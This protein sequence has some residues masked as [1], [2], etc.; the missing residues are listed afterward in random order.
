[1][2]RIKQNPLHEPNFNPGAIPARGEKVRLATIGSTRVGGLYC[3]GSHH[4][5]PALDKA[6]DAIAQDMEGFYMGR[7]DVRFESLGKLR[8]GSGFTI[9]EVNGSGS[10][11]VHA[12]DPKYSIAESY[13]IIFAKQRLLFHIA[14][15]N[16]RKGHKPIGLFKLARLHFHQQKLIMRYPLS[17]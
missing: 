12:W 3:D 13:G 15:A 16:R 1:L 17:N 9:M 8:D 6:V 7:F 2:H 10:E 4:I 11:S 14:E 5:T